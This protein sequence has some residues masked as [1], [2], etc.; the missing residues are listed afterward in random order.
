M[1]ILT[2][3]VIMG[4]E[5][6][7]D[8]QSPYLTRYQTPKTRFGSLMLHVFHRSD[9]VELHDHPWSYVSIILWRG[10]IEETP[11]GR[12]RKYP[13]MILIRPASTVHRVELINEKPAITAVWSGKRIREWGFFTS[14][15]WQNWKDYF[16]ERG[17]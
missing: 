1:K 6:R 2:R 16:K 14:Q 9:S 3:K 7:G 5:Q 17:C 4:C 8:A 12:R 10:Y 13:G 15:G 11:Q